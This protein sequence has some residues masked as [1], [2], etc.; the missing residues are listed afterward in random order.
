ML[1]TACLLVAILPAI[2]VSPA[3]AQE[4]PPE[5]KD[6]LD[7]AERDRVTIQKQADAAITARQARLA[8]DLKSVERQLR[9]QGKLAAAARVAEESAKVGGAVVAEKRVE[10]EWNGQ[11]YPAKVLKTEGQRSFIHY[12]NYGP[13]WDEW[14]GPNRIRTVEAKPAVS[15]DLGA[16]HEVESG[17]A[18]YPG[19]ILKTDE[20]ARRHYVLYH[21]KGIDWEEWV[22]FDRVRPLTK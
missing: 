15:R 13:E 17:D 18:W 21:T 14:V 12:E 3:F 19:K 7:V 5:A 22:P 9:L 11:W 10:V 4:L 2:A 8:L 20:K 1:R 6:V 16:R